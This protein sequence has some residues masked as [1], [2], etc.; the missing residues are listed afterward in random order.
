MRAFYASIL[1]AALV[2]TAQ[3]LGAFAAPTLVPPP[4]WTPKAM[5]MNTSTTS[6][7][8]AWTAPTTHD[9][10]TE[11]IN[12]ASD[13]STGAGFDAFIGTQRQALLKS[14]TSSLT[15]DADEP[16]A[17]G[18]AHR[19]EYST[20]FGNHNLT[21]TQLIRITDGAAYVASYARLAADKPDPAALTS[22][23]TL[24]NASA[25]PPSSLRG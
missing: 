22:L 13:S 2:A 1:L 14:F 12:L 20:P 6:V 10:F 18:T 4:G 21:L 9:G 25:P 17:G 11:S 16:C 15:V 23:L 7:L 19:F 8:A 3:P 24:C 5:D